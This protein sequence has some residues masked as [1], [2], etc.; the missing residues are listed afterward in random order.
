MTV[1]FLVLLAVL[2]PVATAVDYNRRLM[3]R[4]A[5][6]LGHF[7]DLPVAL[8]NR[9]VLFRQLGG[10]A[11]DMAPADRDALIRF[12]HS[13]GRVART[14][15]GLESGHYMWFSDDPADPKLWYREPGESG[16]D[17][18]A[19]P[20]GMDKFAHL[21]LQDDGT[22]ADCLLQPGDLYV[23][24]N[25]ENE[26]NNI[27]ETRPLVSDVTNGHGCQTMVPCPD[28]V[29]QRNC[30]A[31]AAADASFDQQKCRDAI[32]WCPHYTVRQVTNQEPFPRGFLPTR[33][34]CVNALG[35]PDGTPGAVVQNLLTG[36]LG[37][38]H[39]LDGTT[40]LV[41]EQQGV[42]A[43]DF[44]YCGGNGQ[45]CNNTY[46]GAY[47]NST[48]DPRFRPWYINTRAVQKPIWSEPFVFFDDV[49]FGI[50]YSQPI[51]NVLPDGTQVFK[52][53]I[54]FDYILD[55]VT[56]HLFEA[57]NGTDIHV[58]VVESVAP[59]YVVASSSGSA[60]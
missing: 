43:G 8:S 56:R 3:G 36:E 14:Y 35:Q 2:C 4:V 22:P 42:V 38:C 10:F 51:Y 11:G 48:Y 1:T 28:E 41:P 26:N 39:Y 25:K 44:A 18:H 54:A 40:P 19:P 17:W 29:S 32:R 23:E 57:Y 24:C 49:V 60:R 20:A 6:R 59:H 7:L 5:E 58:L 12:F 13:E 34:L 50:T 31:L 52:G 16:Y 53:V 45:V 33:Y 37:D 15:Y 27:Q 55:E 46:P 9:A 30:T 47:S 21:C